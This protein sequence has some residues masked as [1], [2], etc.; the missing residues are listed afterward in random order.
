MSAVADSWM[1]TFDFPA[2]MVAMCLIWP[3]E[4]VK[5]TDCVSVL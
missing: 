1:N 4:T 3:R 2:G 5:D